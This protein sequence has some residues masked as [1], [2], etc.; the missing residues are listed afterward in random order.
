MKL[1]EGLFSYLTGNDRP[2][3]RDGHHEDDCDGVARL[4]RAQRH[5]PAGGVHAGSMTNLIQV[6]TRVKN[7]GLKWLQK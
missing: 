4:Q 2:R 7:S 1:H 6:D 3:L 5:Q